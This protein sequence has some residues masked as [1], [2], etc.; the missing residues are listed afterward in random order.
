MFQQLILAGVLS[1]PVVS[2]QKAQERY[3]ALDKDY[4]MVNESKWIVPFSFKPFGLNYETRLNRDIIVPLVFVLQELKLRGLIS[5]ITSFHGCFSSRPVSGTNRPSIHAY[6]LGCDFNHSKFSSAFV[7]VW[8]RWGFTWG[9][10]FCSWKDW[11]HFSY[12]WEKGEC[13]NNDDAAIKE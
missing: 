2:V 9:G 5:E 4:R 6:G 1:A 12:S 10:D 7:E 11:M 8:K 3:G 13:P